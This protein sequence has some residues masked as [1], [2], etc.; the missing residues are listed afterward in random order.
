[1]VI[2]VNRLKDDG[3]TT[4]GTLSVDGAF[5][6]FTIE[7][8]WHMVKVHS[9]TC[10]PAGSYEIKLRTVGGMTSVYDKRYDF[11]EG[12]LWLQDVPGFKWVYIHT[13]NKS[14][15]SEG[16]ILVNGVCDSTTGNM[17]G[18]KSVLAYT[19]LYKSIIAEINAGNKVTINIA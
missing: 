17:R 10:I 15:H 11:H 19:K 16:C 14:S 9:E 5:E 18:S 8:T 4:I 6:C 3:E 13:G 7:D 2:A 12:M 1:M